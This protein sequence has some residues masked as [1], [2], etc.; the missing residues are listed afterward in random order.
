MDD[1]ELQSDGKAH[2][3]NRLVD[4]I[5]PSYDINFVNV[6]DPTDILSLS[7]VTAPGRV[8][9]TIYELFSHWDY[10]TSCLENNMTINGVWER[11]DA[12]PTDVNYDA[13]K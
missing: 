13:S 12:L 10:Q 6:A 7:Q 9:R 1:V 11:N 3:I 4:N 2:V 8:S 5:Q